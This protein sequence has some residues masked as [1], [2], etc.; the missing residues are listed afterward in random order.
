[1][2]KIESCSVF[3]HSQI[4][5]TPDLKKQLF[6]I[7]ENL[8]SSGCKYFY[9]GG[10]GMFDDLC[11]E[12]ISNLKEKYKHIH[13]IYCLT[14]EKHLRASKRPRYLKDNDYEQFVYLDLNFDWWYTRIYYRNIAIID[15][16]DVVIFYVE[17]RK[18]SGAYKTYKYAQK[19]HKLIINL[20]K[21]N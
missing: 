12:I 19:K 10:L 4:N 5:I 6:D 11:H 20:L 1:M 16:S 9:F 21:N 14:D 2:E 18:N 15:R 3:G 7:F 8:I 13:R 17:E